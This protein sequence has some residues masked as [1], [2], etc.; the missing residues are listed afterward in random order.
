MH[1]VVIQWAFG[2]AERGIRRAVMVDGECLLLD[3]MKVLNTDLQERP[4]RAGLFSRS[5]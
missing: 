3:K 5:S 1:A 4:C 2:R